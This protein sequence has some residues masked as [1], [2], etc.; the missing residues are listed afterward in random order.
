MKRMV[1]IDFRDE[2]NVTTHLKFT[3]LIKNTI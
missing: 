1:V 2:F 3:S